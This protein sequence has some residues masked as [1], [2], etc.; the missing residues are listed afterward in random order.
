MASITAPG[1]GSGLDVSSL[2]SELVAAEGGPT[3]ARLARREAE[4]QAEISALGSLKAALSQFRDAAAGLADLAAFEGR[5]ASSSNE[6]LFTASATSSAVAGAYSIEVTDLA[7]SHRLASQGYADADATVGSGVLTIA[8]GANSFQVVVDAGDTLGD[9]R[10]AINAAA[11][12]TGV[13]ATT[14]N[15]DDGSGG[16][17]TRLLMSSAGTGSDNALTITVSDDDGTP[18]NLSGLSAFIYDPAPAG[19]GVENL[20]QLQGADDAVIKIDTQTVTR[21]SNTIDDAIDGVTINLVD[22][23]VG[24]PATLTVLLDTGSVKDRISGFVASFNSLNSTVAALSSF[25]AETLAAG[26]LLGDPTLRGVMSGIRRDL[27]ARVDGLTGSLD[28]LA[29]IGVRTGAEGDLSVDAA[30]LSKALE[31]NFEDVGLLFAAAN[32]VA[33]RLESAVEPYVQ[34]NGTI[35]SRTEGLTSRV[36]RIDEQ[37]EALDRRL[38]SMQS[39]LLAQFTAMDLLVGRLNSTG[40]FLSQQLDAIQSLASGRRDN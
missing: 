31:T 3:S 12:N 6:E 14:V 28:S 33:V 40:D 21:S 25:D 37:R 19:S 24:E 38:T 26:T 8:V 27:G 17:E 36:A 29:A 10:D 32:G 11:D 35:D 18:T 16:T 22:A 23:A 7:K 2:I 15:V 4:A 34:S 30:A 20:D 9:V 1:V 13:A 5:S 39:R